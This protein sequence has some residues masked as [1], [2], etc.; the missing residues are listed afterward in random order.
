MFF[1]TNLETIFIVADREEEV[2]DR[3]EV[4][5]RD[6]TS[7][8]PTESKAPA[9]DAEAVK[10]ALGSNLRFIT[11]S[12]VLRTMAVD[13]RA[14]TNWG[15]PRMV[16]YLHWSCCNLQLEAIKAERGPRVE[17]GSVEPNKPLVEVLREAKEAKEAAFQAV[18][19]SMKV[20]EDGRL[21][22]Y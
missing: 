12:E 4:L 21:P 22:V 20:G 5:G 13:S 8:F 18:W 3:E 16:F 15:C 14:S 9:M 19:K 10:A 6:A 7:V 1:A 2:Y 17:D 11:E